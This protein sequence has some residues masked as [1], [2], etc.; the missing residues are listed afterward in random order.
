MVAAD[1][2]IY[3]GNRMMKET[4][5]S[6]MLFEK[7]VFVLF[8]ERKSLRFSAHQCLYSF[9]WKGVVSDP[10][11]V[12]SVLEKGSSH[13]PVW[14]LWS[15]RSA[16]GWSGHSRPCCPSAGSPPGGAR[17]RSS[18]ERALSCSESETMATTKISL[19]CVIGVDT[20]CVTVW[21]FLMC[22]HGCAHTARKWH[23]TN[24][25]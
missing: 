5:C 3:S 7:Q 15:S 14:W 25:C 11:W 24:R 21:D 9:L 16:A 17:E 19:I 2:F 6:E 18:A 20:F 8:W 4:L 22:M 1:F 12:W 10:R 23:W 13:L